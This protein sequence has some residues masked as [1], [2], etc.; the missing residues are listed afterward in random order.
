MGWIRFCYFGWFCTCS[1]LRLSV[2]AA[3]DR[4]RVDPVLLH[5]LWRGAV[6]LCRPVRHRSGFVL[7]ADDRTPDELYAELRGHLESC[8]CKAKNMRSSQT[9]IDF[10]Y[11]F[12]EDNGIELHK[13]QGN[14]EIVRM[15]DALLGRPVL[16]IEDCF[17]DNTRV[18]EVEVGCHV[19][20]IEAWTFKG[21]PSLE[22][23]IIPESVTE[24]DGHAILEC[25]KAVIYAS[26]GS[27]AY[28]FAR[29]RGLR[30]KRLRGRRKHKNQC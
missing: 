10:V 18:R 14:D 1:N 28:E 16:M 12:Y 24:I 17:V 4:L 7:H 30:V 6:L 11:Y 21:C 26:R 23:I 29:K 19:R 13:Y 22:R 9:S 25:P 3:S 8:G 2:C 27:Y 5:G 20:T 15:P